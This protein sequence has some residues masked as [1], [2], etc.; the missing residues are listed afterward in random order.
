MQGRAPRGLSLS[1]LRSEAA[2]VGSPHYIP[3]KGVFPHFERLLLELL[4]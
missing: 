1:Q 2:A 4:L 3:T